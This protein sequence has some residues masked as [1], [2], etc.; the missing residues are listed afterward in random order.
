MKE[1]N[2]AKEALT[3]AMMS[4]SVYDPHR[5]FK[6]LPATAAGRSVPL[7][8]GLNKLLFV[9]PAATTLPPS[10]LVHLRYESVTK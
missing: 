5:L 1:Y 6:P 2:E 10:E 4:H 3:K 7:D 8:T 9:P